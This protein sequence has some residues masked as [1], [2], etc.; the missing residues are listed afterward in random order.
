MGR[1]PG[2]R[3]DATGEHD[4]R[5]FCKLDPAL[6]HYRRTILSFVRHATPVSLL[7]IGFSAQMLWLQ[8]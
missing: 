6:A 5:N 4:F 8:G 3:G 1:M 2:M 7:T